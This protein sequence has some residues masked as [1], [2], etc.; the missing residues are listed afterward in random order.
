MPIQQKN[1]IKDKFQDGDNPSGA[2]FE[3]LIDSVYPLSSKGDLLTFSDELNARLPVGSNGQVLSADS[4]AVSGLRWIDVTAN[5]A[6]LPLGG[7]VLTGSLILKADPVQPLEAATKQYV[8]N[9][10]S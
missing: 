1:S 7:G 4:N 8:D 9:R 3:N 6:F 2:D 10:I 5:G